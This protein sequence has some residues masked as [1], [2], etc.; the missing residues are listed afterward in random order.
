MIL[1]AQDRKVFVNGVRR[2]FIDMVEMNPDPLPF[3]DTA[4]VR[5]RPQKAL[6]LRVVWIDTTHA[7]LNIEGCLSVR[8]QPDSRTSTLRVIMEDLATIRDLG[9]WKGA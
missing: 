2:V 1:Y 6:P 5:V 7:K 4:A 3:A 9:G 8:N